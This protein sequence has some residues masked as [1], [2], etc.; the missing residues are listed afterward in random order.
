M[1]E[2]LHSLVPWGID[3]ILWVQGFRSPFLNTFFAVMTALG[4]EYFYI[5]LMG[6]LY[7]SI[8]RPLGLRIG[9]AMVAC[10]LYTNDVLKAVVG[11]P[12]PTEAQVAVLAHETTPAF[13]S[14]HSQGAIVVWGYLASRAS[15]AWIWVLAATVTLLIGLSRIYLGV[16]YPQDVLGGFLL[17]GTSLALFIGVERWLQA[18]Q[19]PLS[20]WVHWA[21]AVG[22]PLAIFA[23]YPRYEAG[24]AVGLLMGLGIGQWMEARYVR[25]SSTGPWW[26]RLVRFVLGLLVTLPF[27]FGLS[28]LLPAT[29]LVRVVRYGFMGWLA[30]FVAPWIFVRLGLVTLRSKA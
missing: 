3:A 4:N 22:L 9:Y 25:F 10:Y 17:G 5:A 21:F 30:V 28:A 7:W 11:I 24:L 18:R 15:R 27:Y 1:I 8:N 20:S 23:L 12:R 14:G 26:Q 13:P 2:W 19:T 16:H 29:P 6:G